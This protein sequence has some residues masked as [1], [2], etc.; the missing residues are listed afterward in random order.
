LCHRRLEFN[1]DL[2]ILDPFEELAF[3]SM[4]CER[5]G[6]IWIGPEVTSIYRAMSSDSCAP[7]L[8]DFYLSNRA[9]HRAVI[10]AWHL[11]DIKVWD[12][13]SVCVQ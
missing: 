8:F 12:R 7:D 9:T 3:L 5:A 10:A 6:A 11:R 2:R 1:R 4:E 13:I